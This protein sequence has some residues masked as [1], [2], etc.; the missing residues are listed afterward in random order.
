MRFTLIDEADAPPQPARLSKRRRRLEISE[1]LDA[2]TPSL[3]GRISPTK[4]EN[5]AKTWKLVFEVAASRGTRIDAWE[6]E[7]GLLY[8]RLLSETEH[9]TG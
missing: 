8:V 7:D 2:L 1:L 6:G 3:V 5:V 4:D 9:P